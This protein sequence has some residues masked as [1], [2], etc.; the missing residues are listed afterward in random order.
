MNLYEYMDTGKEEKPFDRIVTDGGFCSIF[1][2]IACVGDSL[3]SGEFQS[4]NKEGNT[5]YHDM[6]EYSWVQFIARS[7][8]C[9]V[10]NFSRGGMTAKEYVESF[11]EQNG[12]W[13]E[14]KLCQ[15]YIIALGVN[16]I[17]NQGMELGGLE[18]IDRK[19]YRKN[20]SS[21]AG[22]YGQIIQRVKVLQPRAK[23][24]LV[25]MPRSGD[26]RDELRRRHR[27]ILQEMCGFFERTY[28]IDLYEYAPVYD[29]GF[30]AKYFLAG[31]MS[32]AGYLLTAHMIESYIDFI[33]RKNPKEFKQVMYIGT[34]LYQ[35]PE[36]ALE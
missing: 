21:F 3:S 27:D 5:G 14:D 24:F 20:K 1:R 18:D 15:A 28:L 16:D 23:F 7:T 12:F 22:Y 8:G 11:A 31:H 26:K 34:D 13:G 36:E 35:E 10:Y 17:I 6:Y 4:L 33:I 25:S 30:E 9:K 32:P 2:S 29:E 19:D